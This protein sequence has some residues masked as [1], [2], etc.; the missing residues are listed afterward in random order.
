VVFSKFRASTA[1]TGKACQ[2]GSLG[3]EGSSKAV[4]QAVSSKFMLNK[5]TI[6]RFNIQRNLLSPFYNSTF[7]SALLWLLFEQFRNS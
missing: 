1:D 7:F 3:L 6:I 2:E 4:V 5:R